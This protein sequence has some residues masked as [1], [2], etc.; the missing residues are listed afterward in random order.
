MSSAC[1]G[2]LPDAARGDGSGERSSFEEAFDQF[3]AITTIRAIEETLML[4]MS[5]CPRQHIASK[6]LNL[7]E[8]G[9]HHPHSGPSGGARLPM[10]SAKIDCEVHSCF[11]GR[12]D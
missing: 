11:S 7:A 8:N 2:T 6:V 3:I 12:L 9:P 10:A 4:C 5:A 1:G